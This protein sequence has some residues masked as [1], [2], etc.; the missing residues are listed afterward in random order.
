MREY[1][2]IAQDLEMYGVNYFDIKNKKSTELY[3]GVDALGLNV[4]DKNDKLTPKIGFPWSEIRNISFNDKKFVIKPV[5][6]KSPDFVFYARRIRVNKRILALCM[7]NHELYMPERE[8]LNKEIAAREEAEQKQKEYEERLQIMQQEMLRA[9]NELRDAQ[10]MIGRLEK[11]L[12]EYTQAKQALEARESELRALNQR[13]E[14]EREM[15][16]SEKTK[17]LEEIQKREEEIVVFRKEVDDKDRKTRELQSEVEAARQRE[18]EATSALLSATTQATKHNKENSVFEHTEQDVEENDHENGD[19]NVD[20]TSDDYANVPQNEIERKT[21][22][23][24]NRNIQSQ[25]E[26]LNAELEKVRVQEKVTDY[27]V[28]HMEN[29]RA[30]RDKYKT[31]KQIRAGNT[32]RRIDQFEN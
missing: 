6:K 11:Q 3:L 14:Q 26:S 30:G 7:G 15:E 28:L 10:D 29:K 31:L 27:D 12:D 23:E 9:Q 13:I 19:I 16:S 32:Q 25:L 20:L 24:T 8:K 5:D 17:L 22:L 18:L 1:L 4:Y 21:Q 2:K